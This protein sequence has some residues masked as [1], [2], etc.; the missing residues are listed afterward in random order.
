LASPVN[1]DTACASPDLNPG[2]NIPTVGIGAVEN[3][4]LVTRTALPELV[5]STAPADP[6][7]L[8][9]A[10]I[11]SSNARDS[12]TASVKVVCG[13]AAGHAPRKHRYTAVTDTGAVYDVLNT[14]TSEKNGEAAVPTG[15]DVTAGIVNVSA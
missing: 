6:G 10:R 13:A 9:V 11:M 14:R 2:T 12:R 4:R 5:N 1:T 3:N 8:K 15:S 7:A